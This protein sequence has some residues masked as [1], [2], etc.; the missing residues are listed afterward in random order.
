MPSC[1]DPDGRTKKCHC[2]RSDVASSNAS[3]FSRYPTKS[4]LR[5]ICVRRFTEEK[6]TVRLTAMH[7]FILIW[8]H[9]VGMHVRNPSTVF[10]IQ[11]PHRPGVSRFCTSVRLLVHANGMVCPTRPPQTSRN[12]QCSFSGEHIHVR[13][14]FLSNLNTICTE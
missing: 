7:S 10:L 11:A 3:S 13:I 4:W 9:E 14:V 8:Y 1:L 6:R 5:R 2:P 12:S